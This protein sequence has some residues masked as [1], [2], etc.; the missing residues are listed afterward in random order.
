MNNEIGA[1][2]IS[3]VKEGED[4]PEGGEGVTTH[5]G[6]TSQM[7]VLTHDQSQAVISNRSSAGKT[8]DKIDW[9]KVG[10]IYKPESAI[11]DILAKEVTRLS[12]G[13]EMSIDAME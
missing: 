9:A 6:P 8:G 10:K 7:G 11:E 2:D 4:A 3:H 13:F 1:L 12:K 5:G